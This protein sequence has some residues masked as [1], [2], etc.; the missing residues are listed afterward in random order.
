MKLR[1]NIVFRNPYSFVFSS[2]VMFIFSL[3]VFWFCKEPVD[4][5]I[6][7]I[8]MVPYIF[9][10]LG[11]IFELWQYEIIKKNREIVR[12]TT[13]IRRSLFINEL[14]FDTNL[15]KYFA[16]ERK[17]LEDIKKDKGTDIETLKNMYSLE[18]LWEVN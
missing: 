17:K 15:E 1:E 13:N 18:K 9:L 3:I 7:F 10:C 6:K 12:N 2:I 16:F 14:P 4:R 8:V 5:T 11:Y